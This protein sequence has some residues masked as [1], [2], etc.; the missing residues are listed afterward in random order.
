MLIIQNFSKF[1]LKVSTLAEVT[2]S[3]DK[4]FQSFIIRCLFKLST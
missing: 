3:W 1:D 4:E 2:T